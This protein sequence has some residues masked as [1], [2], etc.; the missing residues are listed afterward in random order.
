MAPEGVRMTPARFMQVAF[1]AAKRA[2]EYR[3]R[4]WRETFRPAYAGPVRPEN[5]EELYREGTRLNDALLKAILALN[6]ARKAW[7]ADAAE[8]DGVAEAVAWPAEM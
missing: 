3:D 1:E 4:F 6:D 5:H 8:R 2:K 7:V